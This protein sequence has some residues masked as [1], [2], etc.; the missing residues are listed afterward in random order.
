[1][2]PLDLGTP[3]L[4]V[5]R[6]PIG[7]TTALLLAHWGVRS[8]IVDPLTASE[9]TAGSKAVL[10]AGHVMEITEP[11]GVGERI[12]GEGLAWTKSRT[13]IRGQEV[14]VAHVEHQHQLLPRLVN[15]P[16]HRVE[17]L[18]LEK[19]KSEPLITLRAEN[20]LVGLTQESSG[21]IAD[22]ESAAGI[23]RVRTDWL[24]GADGARSTVRK[25]LNTPF[26]GFGLD[27]NFLLV[28]V[29]AEL[30]RPAER[31]FHFDPSFNPR[32]SVLIH[33]QPN[34]TWH[35]D[36]QVVPRS[37]LPKNSPAAGSTIASVR[38]SA[39]STMSCSGIRATDSNNSAPVSSGS[40]GASWPAMPH[41]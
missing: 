24:I 17:E 18:L 10:V 19:V 27:V 41:T 34:S 22:L 20:R 35:I 38:C 1:M 30:R 39:P 12:A 31:H 6:G 8:T 2:E 36:W 28:N 13:F 25:A 37:T 11:I 14:A 5:G 9:V 15:L 26:E 3:V 23:T 40:A 16:Q 21:V 7:M 32:R 29:R 33:P 4:I